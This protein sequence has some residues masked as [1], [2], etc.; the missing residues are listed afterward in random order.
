MVLAR[1]TLFGVFLFISAFV[2]GQKHQNN[3]YFGRYA[4]IL[5]DA[6]TNTPS[7]GK[8]NPM[9][10][11]TAAV[12]ISDSITGELLFY[13]NGRTVWNKNHNAMPN[14]NNIVTAPVQGAIAIPNPGNRNQY[15]IFTVEINRLLEYSIIDMSLNGGLGDVITKNNLL[16]T[17]TA[18]KLAAVK[19]KFNNAYWLITHSNTNPAQNTFWAYNITENGITTTPVTSKIGEVG[20][21]FGDFVSDSKGSKLA[22]TTYDKDNALAQVFDFDKHCGTV[23]NAKTLYKDNDWDYAFGAA[24]S[25]NDEVLYIAY[26]YKES[27]LVQYFGTDFTNWAVVAQSDANY[28]DILIGPDD[29]LYIN[30]HFNNV[31]SRDVDVLHNPNGLGFAVDFQQDFLNLGDTSNGNFQFPNFITDKSTPKVTSATHG[32]SITFTNNCIGDSTLFEQTS[33][34][35][36]PDSLVWHFQDPY[37]TDSVSRLMKPKHKYS[38]PGKYWVFITYYRCGLALKMAQQINIID[39][40]NVYLGPDTTICYNDSVTLESNAKGLQHL[41]NTGETTETITAKNSGWYWVTVTSPTCK[42]TD[43]IYLT[44]LPPIL[45]DLGDG[46]TVCEHDTDD[47]VKLDAGKGYNKYKWMPTQD[48][49]QWIIVKQAGEYYVV[50]EDYR[51]CRGDD[52]SKVARLCDF[53]FYMPNAFTPNGDGINDVFMPTALDIV[54]L[55]FE[56][57]NAWGERVFMTSNPQQGWDGTYKGKLSPQGI[58]LYKIS[59]KGYSN[60]LLRNYNF[61]GTVSLL[62]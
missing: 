38:K 36:I 57:F 48:T 25:P 8:D 55:E 22:L 27:Q 20:N 4:S 41:W 53:D 12:S 49:S 18:S 60:K 40:A 61:K 3:W 32:L 23:S 59:F 21:K 56:I 31:P 29:K 28:N 5:F 15:Y 19:H 58:Y 11:P 54:D 39:A 16:A 33:N 34:T 7:V 46:Y 14:G 26:S 2:F 1:N 30:T 37:S 24:F 44:K 47:L 62:R 35:N 13:S 42:A 43:S 50:V 9:V 6:T 52:G 51:G 10:Y 45:I 17:N